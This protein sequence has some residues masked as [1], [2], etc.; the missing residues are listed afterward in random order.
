M[1]KH[2]AVPT[3]LWEEESLVSGITSML[4]EQINMA[5]Y[6]LSDADKASNIAVLERTREVIKKTRVKISVLFIP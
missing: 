6:T 1:V 5:M 4:E 2:A 3:V